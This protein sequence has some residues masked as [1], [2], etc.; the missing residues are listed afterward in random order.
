MRNSTLMALGLLFALICPRPFASV[1]ADDQQA[2]PPIP[3]ALENRFRDAVRPF[4]ETYCIGCHGKDKPKG[5]L[6]LS[7]YTTVGAVAKDLA[8]WEAVLEQLKS[9]TMPPAKA[10]QH[11]TDEMRRHVVEW[12]QAIRTLDARRNAGDPGRVLARRLSNAEYDYTIRDL[13]GADLRPTREFPVDPANEAGFDNSSESLAMSPA[14]VKKYLEAARFVADHLVL[15]PRGFAF[16][17]YL[18]IADTDRDKYCVRQIIDFYKGQRTDYADYFFA[19][20]RYRHRRPLGRPAA[21]LGDIA[22]EAGISRKYLETVWSL[23]SEPSGEAGPVAAVQS[24]WQALPAPGNDGVKAARAGCEQ[25]RDFVV[26]LRQRVKPQVKNLNVRGVNNGSQSLVLWKNRQY[27]FN[28]RRYDAGELARLCPEELRT[29]TPEARTRAV[30]VSAVDRAR[31]EPAFARFCSTFPDA[32]FISERA[33]VYLDPKEDRDNKGRLLSA[34]FHSMTGYFRDDAPLYDLILDA[35]GQ[36]ELDGLWEEFD[37]ITGAPMRQYASFLWF[38]RA[39]SG[40]VRGPSFDFVRAEDKDAGSPAKIKRLAEV[41]LEKVRRSHPSE[42]GI[43]AITA[44]FEIIAASIRRSNRAGSRRN[45]VI[46]KPCR[47]SP[48]G[49]TAV[50]CQRPSATASPRFI[51]PY[52]RATGSITKTP[53]ATRS[54]ACSCRRTSATASTCRGRA[55]P[56]GHCRITRS[57]AA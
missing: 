13:T 51:T 48:S 52:A 4:L 3:P 15:K 17:P 44:H 53:C 34:G 28:R 42:T 20:W 12:I 55:P 7:G 27:V 21:S 45:P 22:T 11:P 37:F 24:M 30:P 40:F 38:E 6:D 18:M 14:L 9:G 26:E 47:R 39:E 19:A 43:E 57:P 31:Y 33:R 46:S 50:R 23:L 8:Q 5:D 25:L 32:F 16:A 1:R 49:R 2:S 29:G 35:A 41:Y 56:S 10:K 36:R 54:S